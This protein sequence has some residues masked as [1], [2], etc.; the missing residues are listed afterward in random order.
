MNTSF[1]IRKAKATGAKVVD[2]DGSY[3]HRRLRKLEINFRHHL[4]CHVRC[5][6]TLSM[7]KGLYNVYILLGCDGNIATIHSA[8][9]EC[10]AGYVALF[11]ISYYY[12][13]SIF[14]Q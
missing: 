12:L 13:L 3:L 2:V 4:F 5:Q 1:G 11:F 9:C 10:A 8:T 14:P 7:K 6:M